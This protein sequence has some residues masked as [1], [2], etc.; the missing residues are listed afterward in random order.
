MLEKQAVYD[1]LGRTI[2]MKTEKKAISDHDGHTLLC[3]SCKWPLIETGKTERYRYCRC[4]N[5]GSSGTW[6]R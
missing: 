6:L 5:C 3:P 4:G 2:E 1:S